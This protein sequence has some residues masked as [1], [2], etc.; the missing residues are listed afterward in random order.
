L[1]ILV[2]FFEGEGKIAYP[3]FIKKKRKAL[4]NKKENERKIKRKKKR[5]FTGRSSKGNF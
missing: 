4:Q 5:E 1:K 3:F 2:F